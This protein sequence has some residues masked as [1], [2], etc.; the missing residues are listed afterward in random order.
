[1]KISVQ[2]LHLRSLLHTHTPSH[3]HVLGVFVI[4]NKPLSDVD[5]TRFQVTLEE[6][7]S[8][9]GTTFHS[10]LDRSKACII[11]VSS[12]VPG[13]PHPPAENVWSI[14]LHFLSQRRVQ[15]RCN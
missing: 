9:S 12:L 11:I 6:L 15:H 4:P 7:E 5:L 10:R 3:N 8:Q 1:M 2:F 13:H 14:E